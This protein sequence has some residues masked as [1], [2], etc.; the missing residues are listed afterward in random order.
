MVAVAEVKGL[1]KQLGS[2]GTRGL[3][4][5]VERIIVTNFNPSFYCTIYVNK[6]DTQVEIVSNSFTSY[7]LILF[8]V[9]LTK[10][11]VTPL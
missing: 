9:A 11:T 3:H 10:L 1:W 2:S 4:S 6:F 8:Q 5:S 7:N